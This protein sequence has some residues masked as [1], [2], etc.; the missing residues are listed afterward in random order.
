M[1]ENPAQPLVCCQTAGLLQFFR[2]TV[3]YGRDIGQT[4]LDRGEGNNKPYSLGVLELKT[5]RNTTPKTAQ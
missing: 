4:L 3:E 1:V 2:L 5:Q